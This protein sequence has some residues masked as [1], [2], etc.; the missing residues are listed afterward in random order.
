MTTEIIQ[1]LEKIVGTA[2]V[3][4]SKDDTHEYGQDWS[5]LFTP[6]ALAIVRPG[7]IDE[8]QLIVKYANE[9]KVSAKKRRGSNLIYG[10]Q[11][12]HLLRCPG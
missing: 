10:S 12:A 8:V 2:H 3:L 9:H 6:D 5:K 7:T 1:A 11:G 4:T